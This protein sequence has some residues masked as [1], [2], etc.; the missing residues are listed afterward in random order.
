MYDRITIEISDVCNAKCVWCYTGRKNRYG[1]KNAECKPHFMNAAEFERGLGQLINNGVLSPSA[2]IELYNWGE[3][4]LNPDLDGILSVIEKYD[5]P[6]HLST[7]CSYLK[8]FTGEHLKNMTLFMVSLS[9][10]SQSTYG[11][12]HGFD[13]Q[14]ILENINTAAEILNSRGLLHL[15]EIN[16]HVYNFNIHEIAAARKY[17]ESR[18]IR[19]V[20]RTAY[21]NDYYLF[22]KFL[23][24]RLPAKTKAAARRHLLTDLLG[25]E[26]SFAPKKF[27]CPQQAKIVVDDEWNLIP[28][29]RLSKEEQLGNILDMSLE[30]IAAAKRSVPQCESCLENGQAYIVHQE[31]KF[32]YGVSERIV[33][34]RFI[35]KLL[36]DYSGKGFYWFS[37]VC[38]GVISSDGKYS[39]RFEFPSPPK[40][41]RV[42]VPRPFNNVHL[43]D[44]S[45]RSDAGILGTSQC[46]RESRKMSGLFEKT[47]AAFDICL[48][49]K[50]IKWVEISFG[51]SYLSDSFVNGIS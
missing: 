18:N 45:V 22:D 10:F 37:T 38:D 27:A 8:Y 48:D 30:E 47:S 39:H 1:Q 42:V 5:M 29:C 41:L 16:F 4:L 19:F 44:V 34:Y 25:E 43:A 36:V 11:K 50:A 12:I 7:N 13:F 26:A 20:A 17:F 6:F 51:V 40:K 31:L 14:R 2:E 28:C 15:M 33:P 49:G 23:N 46:S 3:P 21:F 35:P 24:D 32:Q 9:G